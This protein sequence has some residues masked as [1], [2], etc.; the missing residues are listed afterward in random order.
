MGSECDGETIH[1]DF[2][3]TVNL[4]DISLDLTFP[5]SL[6]AKTYAI[7]LKNRCVVWDEFPHVVRLYLDPA[8]VRR[9][10]YLTGNGNF[11]VVFRDFPAGRPKLEP[12]CLSK[13]ELLDS[14][15][16]KTVDEHT[17]A[18]LFDQRWKHSDF[19]RR[20]RNEITD[21]SITRSSTDVDVIRAREIAKR[22]RAD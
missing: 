15:M 18:I 22:S 14:K 3:L 11:F 9:V 21:L 4:A 6:W 5:H 8:Y 1:S 10:G 16:W 19:E 2:E 20:F 13:I 12:L 17:G 7:R